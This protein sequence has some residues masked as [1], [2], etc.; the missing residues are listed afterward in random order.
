MLQ[1]ESV[2]RLSQLVHKAFSKA[3]IN[4]FTTRLDVKVDSMQ[5]EDK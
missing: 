5:K 2:K 3:H 1:E 4:E